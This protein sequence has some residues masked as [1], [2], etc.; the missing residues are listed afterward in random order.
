[1]RAA[2]RFLLEEA[3]VAPARLVYYGESLGSAVVTEL[4]TQHPPAGLVLRSPF[5]DLA[6][7][8]APLR[9]LSCTYR[10]SI[11]DRA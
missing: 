7:P 10:G 9:S 3:E 11:T 8:P 6:S 1:V 5:V 4:A 2:H